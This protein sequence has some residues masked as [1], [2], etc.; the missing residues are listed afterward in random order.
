MLAALAFSPIVWQ[1]SIVLLLAPL[2]VLRPRFG[3]VW[4]LPLLLWFAPDTSG[5]VPVSQLVLFAL[6]VGAVCVAALRV[7]LHPPERSPRRPPESI[8]LA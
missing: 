7:G 4:T 8:T 3:V 5:V 2:A 1:H 6:V